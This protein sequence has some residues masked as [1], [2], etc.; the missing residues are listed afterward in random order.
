MTTFEGTHRAA[1]KTRRATEAVIA[2]V[3][4]LVAIGAAVLILT[5]TGASTT[6]RAAQSHPSSAYLPLAH[7]YGTGAPPTARTTQLVTSGN[8]R[9]ANPVEHFYGLQP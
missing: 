8:N 7:F 4:M 1:L 3:G 2:T 6:H 5:L 9:T